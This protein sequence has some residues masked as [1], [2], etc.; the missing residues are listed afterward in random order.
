MTTKRTTPFFLV[1]SL[2]LVACDPPSTPPPP[3]LPPP[4]SSPFFTSEQTE[5]GSFCDDREQPAPFQFYRTND[6]LKN[7]DLRSLT[8]CSAS[9]GGS[10]SAPLLFS[11]PLD[12]KQEQLDPSKALTLKQTP[13]SFKYADAPS[14]TVVLEIK[15]KFA[16]GNIYYNKTSDDY[17]WYSTNLQTLTRGEAYMV[18]ASTDGTTY[19]LQFEY[20]PTH[21]KE[22]QNKTYTF[23]S[24][25]YYF[26]P[27][28]LECL[29]VPLLKGD[30]D[31]NLSY[32]LTS[33]PDA[34]SSAT[35]STSFALD[36]SVTDGKFDTS[37]I[38]NFILQPYSGY[39]IYVSTAFNITMSTAPTG[40]CFTRA[41]PLPSSS[42]SP[43]CSAVATSTTRRRSLSTTSL[44][45]SVCIPTIPTVSTQLETYCQPI[46]LEYCTSGGTSYLEALDVNEKILGCDTPRLSQDGT[47]KSCFVVNSINDINR[48]RAYTST[49]PEEG[50][51]NDLVTTVIIPIVGVLVPGAGIAARKVFGGKKSE[52]GGGGGGGGG[53][54]SV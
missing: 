1:L 27:H 47:C 15:S 24:Q 6:L 43:S 3:V 19:D 41:P 48:I 42:Y 32:E 25:G 26:F 49:V 2:A 14:L 37:S 9:T 16:F 36:Y 50:S 29:T 31:T 18:Q 46:P 4:P 17:F 53:T 21:L 54:V 33:L 51:G 30:D 44:L 22:V 8:C 20:E 34:S 52:D 5:V 38:S 10:A 28:P 40:D 39:Q 35:P 45:S 23:E 11:V 12:S 7:I 13:P